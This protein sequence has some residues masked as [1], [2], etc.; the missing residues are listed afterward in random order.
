S[1]Y[2]LT[3]LSCRSNAFVGQPAPNSLLIYPSG[4]VS[5]GVATHNISSHFT[6]NTSRTG[7][8][9]NNNQSAI[10]GNL[11]IPLSGTKPTTRDQAFSSNY[12]R[13][14]GGVLKNAAHDGTTV[15]AL[16]S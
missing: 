11:G 12:Y 13:P 1:G 10:G 7:V 16:E 3:G 14:N 4:S 5:G 6:I 2:Q 9:L 15:G 8:T